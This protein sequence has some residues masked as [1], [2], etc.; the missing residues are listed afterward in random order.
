MKLLKGCRS[1]VNHFLSRVFV[2][3]PLVDCNTCNRKVPLTHLPQHWNLCEQGKPDP[4]LDQLTLEKASQSPAEKRQVEFGNQ[5]SP[6]SS[7]S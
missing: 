3:E 5:S 6:S 7:S 4:K 2:A 1:L